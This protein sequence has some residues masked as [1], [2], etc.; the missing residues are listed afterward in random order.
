[1]DGQLSQPFADR[2]RPD[3]LELSFAADRLDVDRVHQWLSVESYWATG[4]ERDV[5]VAAVAGSVVVGVYDT[6]APGS[7][8]VAFARV[9]TD[10]A[11]FAWYCDVFVDGDARGR[12]IGTWMSEV[13]VEELTREGVKRMILGTRDAHAVYAKAGFEPMEATWRYMEIDR[14]GVRDAIVA[15][16]APAEQ[17][18]PSGD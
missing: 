2:T 12:G 17:P 11:T 9:V 15:A 14:R 3:G 10:H 18:G 4:R 16:G 6:A 7:P 5:L 13:V 1:M 8:Q